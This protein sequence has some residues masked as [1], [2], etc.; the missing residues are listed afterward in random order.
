MPILRKPQ[1]VA[2]FG[3]LFR[4]ER[5]PD[6]LV[7]AQNLSAQ[8]GAARVAPGTKGSRTV[9]TTTWC[10]PKMPPLP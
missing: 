9:L 1:L 2:N 4:L 10:R 7:G 3:E 6:H 5:A 8:D